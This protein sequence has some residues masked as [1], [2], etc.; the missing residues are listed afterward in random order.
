MV[1]GLLGMIMPRRCNED[2]RDPSAW[3]GYE[4]PV[5]GL[6]FAP[7]GAK[8]RSPGPRAPHLPP[9]CFSY[10][11]YTWVTLFKLLNIKYF[12]RGL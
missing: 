1:Q 6:R 4:E 3:A 11:G 12:Y 7:V 5:Q 10:S 2:F 8:P 9:V